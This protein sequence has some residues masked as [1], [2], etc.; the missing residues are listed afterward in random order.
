MWKQPR[1]ARCSITAGW[2]MIDNTI[3]IYHD[4]IGMPRADGMFALTRCSW[5][6][7]GWC[8]RHLTRKHAEAHPLYA[9][10]L[11][12][13]KRLP[14]VNSP[15]YEETC[16]VRWLA[17]DL[18][19]YDYG[20]SLFTDSDVLNRN[21]NY[22]PGL[23]HTYLNPSYVVGGTFSIGSFE[24]SRAVH[25]VLHGRIHPWIERGGLHASDMV[26]SSWLRKQL[27][28]VD[29]ERFVTEPEAAS[30]RLVNYSNDHCTELGLETLEQR[31]EHWILNGG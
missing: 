18:C 2:A 17:Y 10:Y 12:A 15:A 7:Q 8:V 30:A 5:E 11:A 21:L 22:R 29:L 20:I 19:V 13:A 4:S 9:P 26:H 23:E 14:T 16:W 24:T 3:C 25:D 6:A 28:V 31:K 1:K 27:N